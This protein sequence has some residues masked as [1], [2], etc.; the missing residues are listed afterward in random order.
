MYENEVR[1]EILLSGGKKL[2]CTVT[3]TYI[4]RL[5]ILCTGYFFFI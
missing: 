5:I 2:D 4:Q 1:N 3:L